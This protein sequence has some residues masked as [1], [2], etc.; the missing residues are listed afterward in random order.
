M[1]RQIEAVQV[2]EDFVRERA[3]RM[4]RD[5]SKNRVSELVKKH[6]AS[7]SASIC[8]IIVRTSATD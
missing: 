2:K 3:N 6:A 7:P 5:T 8:N 4:L 1:K